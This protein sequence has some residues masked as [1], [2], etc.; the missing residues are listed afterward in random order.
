MEKW[1]FDSSLPS[2]CKTQGWPRNWPKTGHLLLCEPVDVR[3]S[4]M[5]PPATLSLTSLWPQQDRM[6]RVTEEWPA[7]SAACPRILCSFLL[8]TR[9]LPTAVYDTGTCEWRNLVRSCSLVIG[10]DPATCCIL[11]PSC[12]PP[13]QIPS[14]SRLVLHPK[15]PVHLGPQHSLYGSGK[16][17]LRGL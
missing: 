17:N 1:H 10:A 12:L 14:P 6:C 9:A 15:V 4:K 2:Q 8:T 7:S 13:P 16:T 11:F 3:V 5:I